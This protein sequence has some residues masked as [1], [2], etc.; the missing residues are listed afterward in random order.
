MY[1]PGGVDIAV[2]AVAPTASVTVDPLQPVFGPVSCDKVLE[3]IDD[4][5]SLR[6]GSA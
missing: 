4:G 6:L 3:V 5:N 1:S 2:G